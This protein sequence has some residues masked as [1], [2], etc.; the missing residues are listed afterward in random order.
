M[1]RYRYPIKALAADYVRA[2]IGVFLPLALMIFTK[3]IPVVFYS[4]TALAL[5]FAVYG[6]RTA[7]RHGT[8]LI[9]DEIG[10]RQEGPLGGLL[11]RKLRW[12]EMRDFRLRYYSTERDRKGGWM[13][14]T[15]R[16]GDNRDPGDHDSGGRWNSANRGAIRMDSHLPG[17][18]EIVRR[19]YLA[20]RD[21]GLAIDPTTAANL[22]SLG[23]GS[24]D[25]SAAITDAKSPS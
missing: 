20:A 7:W 15:L 25:P 22:S 21:R 9:V 17:F 12:S 19:A 6:L 23:L 4:M 13:Q 16:R 2:A 3:L 14:L 18:D 8:V 1:N 5:L 10:V 24:N 11:D